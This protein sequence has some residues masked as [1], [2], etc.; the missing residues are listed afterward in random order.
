MHTD[1]SEQLLNLDR[2]L[3]IACHGKIECAGLGLF[4]GA[5]AC[6]RRAVSVHSERDERRLLARAIN[7]DTE[8]PLAHAGRQKCAVPIELPV[9]SYGECGRM[10]CAI[11]RECVRDGPFWRRRG[12]LRGRIRSDWRRL[13]LFVALLDAMYQIRQA[14]HAECA[15]KERNEQHKAS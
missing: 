9:A 13:V 11:S 15:A 3:R 6:T 12:V 5:T 7:V 2:P 8:V 14:T 4:C 1:N 10:A